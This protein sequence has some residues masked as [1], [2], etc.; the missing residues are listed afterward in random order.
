MVFFMVKLL[1]EMVG[2]VA[3]SCTIAVSLNWKRRPARQR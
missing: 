2:I 3:V 1:G